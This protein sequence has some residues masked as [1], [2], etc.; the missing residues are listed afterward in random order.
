M[1]M[2]DLLPFKPLESVF[3]QL[4]TSNANF[5]PMFL[6]KPCAAVFASLVFMVIGVVAFPCSLIGIGSTVWHGVETMQ[7]G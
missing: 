7:P 5:S 4:Q 1:L 6:P 2:L 3:L